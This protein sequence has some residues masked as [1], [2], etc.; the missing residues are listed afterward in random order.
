MSASDAEP[1]LAVASIDGGN[2]TGAG[3]GDDAWMPAG[4]L[5]PPPPPTAGKSYGVTADI[6]FC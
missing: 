4:E 3:N 6:R 5:L 2:T 1:A